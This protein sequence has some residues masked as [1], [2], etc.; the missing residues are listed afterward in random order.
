MN[1]TPY[2]RFKVAGKPYPDAASA[3]EAFH[4]LSNKTS[5]TG[6]AIV[7]TGEFRAFEL[8]GI[9]AAG[10]KYLNHLHFQKDDMMK[11]MNLPHLNQRLQMG[12][13]R[14]AGALV[15]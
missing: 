7:E 13:P 1:T 6:A 3:A 2:P 15:D 14:F 5:Y 9:N 11:A 8:G 10:E 4:K 12:F